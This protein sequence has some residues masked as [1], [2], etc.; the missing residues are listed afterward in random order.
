MR[1]LKSGD[2]ESG[3][4]IAMVSLLMIPMLGFMAL[5]IDVGAWYTQATRVQ[6][7]VDAAALSSVVWMPTIDSPTG[8]P[9]ARSVA[10]ETM[11][12]HGIDFSETFNHSDG[13]TKL[14]WELTV[15]A[16]PAN[17]F[18]VRVILSDNDAPVYFGQLFVDDVQITR[19]AIAE[20]V[21]PV[22]LGSP[23]NSLGIDCDD[24]S[25]TAT[26]S[27][28]SPG[29]WLRSV[30][31]QRLHEHGDFR[32]SGCLN[33]QP[34]D[35]YNLTD[36]NRNSGFDDGGYVFAIDVPT[37]GTWVTVDLFD[38]GFL[39]G[40]GVPD[41][42]DENGGTNNIPTKFTLYEADGSQL[43]TPLLDEVGGDCTRVYGN[44][45]F[46]GQWT[47]STTCNF[48]AD[49]ADIY[50]LRI[51]TAGF[52][53][54]GEAANV[55]SNDTNTYSIRAFN[56]SAGTVAPAF[57]D[58][59]GQPQVYALEMM[60]IASRSDTTV[61]DLARIDDAHAGKTLS[62]RMFD[63]GDGQGDLLLRLTAPFGSL[64]SGGTALQPPTCRFRSW[65]PE[66]TPGDTWTEVTGGC[67]VVT[68]SVLLGKVFNDQWL[69]IQVDL[70][71]S[72]S[73]AGEDCYWGVDYV[74]SE[75]FG[76]GT[77]WAVSVLGDPV[78][79]VG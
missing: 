15:E 6:R 60:S 27:E 56:G 53:G 19:Q 62:A 50:P 1:R 73:C 67:E 7:A 20:F 79:L 12:K 68:R 14:R 31:V 55:A 17:S 5:A 65:D 54:P 75:K 63:T 23:G 37:A 64:I 48:F 8:S 74:A 76:D 59:A 4:A 3:Y 2:K 46:V 21:K 51:Q 11:S 72:Y 16:V 13:S 47:G 71:S 33:G 35:P 26:C 32:S 57:G 34:C 69:E 66:N 49:F 24:A 22:P 77:S 39:A 45:D 42:W 52:T 29:Y 28:G 44:G 18:Q 43:T 38:P 40:R 41:P 61:F 36:P 78:R 70:P 9:D 58:Y 25:P 10:I 30:G